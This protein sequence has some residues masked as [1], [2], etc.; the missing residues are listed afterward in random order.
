MNLISVTDLAEGE[1]R[2]AFP[3]AHIKNLVFQ[4]KLTTGSGNV[5][6]LQFFGTV[7]ADADDDTED[8][9]V[10]ITGLLA[11][12]LELLAVENSTMHDMAILDTDCRFAKIKI[13][14]TI[15]A[16]VPDNAVKIGWSTNKDTY[17]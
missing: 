3:T 14:Y 17:V 6:S 13:K 15:T 16:P 11:G 12:H 8:D 10:N 2:K 5:I 1:Y 4:Y 9:W 7:Y